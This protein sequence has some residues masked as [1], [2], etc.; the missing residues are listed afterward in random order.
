MKEGDNHDDRN[1]RGESRRSS[2]DLGR[3][4]PIS[5]SAGEAAREARSD[6]DAEAAREARS[7]ADEEAGTEGGIEGG[8]ERRAARSSSAFSTAA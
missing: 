5:G 6:A 8:R 4:R 3:S 7:D 2:G 1:G